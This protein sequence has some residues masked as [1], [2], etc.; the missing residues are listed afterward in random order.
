MPLAGTRR[1][2]YGDIDTRSDGARLL[3]AQDE[4][5]FMKGKGHCAGDTGIY[6]ARNEIGAHV[7][8]K[9]GRTEFSARKPSLPR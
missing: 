9:D 2:R 1:A 5:A 4:D 3:R 6:E 8:E 7:G